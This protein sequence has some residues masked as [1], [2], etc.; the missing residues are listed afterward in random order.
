MNIK[1]KIE[2]E[3]KKIVAKLPWILYSKI[4][5]VSKILPSTS[6]IQLTIYVKNIQANISWTNTN[7]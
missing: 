4:R 1:K 3:N 2:S 7:L 6:V 5:V